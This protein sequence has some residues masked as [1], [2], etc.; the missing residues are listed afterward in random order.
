M[1]IHE[2]L[3]TGVARG[4]ITAEQRAAL[5][6][7]SEPSDGAAHA[8]REAERAFNGVT[9]AYA[10][11]ALVVLF[12]FGWFM[13][14][15]WKV[16]GGA[17]LFG[18]SLAYA[19]IFLIVAHVLKREDFRTAQGV[20]MLLAVGMAPIAMYAL[21]VWI[22]VWTP[23]FALLCSGQPHPF[24]ACQGQ[25]MAIELAAIAAALVAMRALPF[26]PF[27]IPI[28]VVS[29]TLPERLLREWIPGTGMDGAVMGWRWVAVASVI[30][31]AA[32]LM[33]RRRRTEDYGVYLWIS[34]ACATWFG[35]LLLFQADHALR[36]YLAPA[37]LLL[38]IASVMLRRR[39]LLVVGLFGLF[40]FLGWLAADVFKVTTTFPLV[41][42][43]LGVTVIILTVWAQKRFPEVIKRMGGDP[44]QPPRFPG[45]ALTMLL[46]ALAALLLAQDAA[47]LDRESAANRRSRSHAAASRNRARRD[48][49]AAERG[50][51]RV[52]E[53]TPQ[54]A[55]PR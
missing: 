22:G 35:G 31:T 6:A 53:Q 54:P 47:S 23:E 28:A 46:P 10:I 55:P 33:D 17:G 27:M 2:L 14:D 18:L 43:L 13:I 32:Y 25:P 49:I 20:A 21:L 11:G 34:V 1:T 36:W 7:I 51:R 19:C 3:D 41:L 8:P 26:A 12:A 37:S 45:G 50:L 38:I 15:R 24:A 4:L 29:V 5:L 44:A 16:L 9:I 42:A 39:A 30:A 52:P 48:S 40:G